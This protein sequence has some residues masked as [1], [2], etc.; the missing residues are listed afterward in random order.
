MRIKSTLSCQVSGV[1]ASIIQARQV[2]ARKS[3]T[4]A[5]SLDATA[6]PSPPAL[7]RASSVPAAT[8]RGESKRTFAERRIGMAQNKGSLATPGSGTKRRCA[9]GAV[10]RR[11]TGSPC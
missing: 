6:V 5:G 1:V 7:V 2:R 10:V 9:I 3:A 4:S 8:A 11:G